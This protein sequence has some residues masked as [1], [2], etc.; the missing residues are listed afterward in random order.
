M[1]KLM[2]HACIRETFI[3]PQCAEYYT[4]MADETTDASNKEQL[5][6]IFRYVDSELLV[7][8]EIVVFIT[9]IQHTPQCSWMSCLF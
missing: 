7:H 3:K 2:S 5:V 4:V 9:S 8:E 6:T 1:V